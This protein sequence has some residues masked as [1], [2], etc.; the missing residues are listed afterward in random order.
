[1]R[2]LRLALIPVCRRLLCIETWFLVCF[3]LAAMSLVARA[4]GQEGE[5]DGVQAHL[6]EAAPTYLNTLDLML[7]RTT[8]PEALKLLGLDLLQQNRRIINGRLDGTQPVTMV[9]YW[10]PRITS[11][12]TVPV[13]I[14]LRGAG[15]RLSSDVRVTARAARNEPEWQANCLYKQAYALDLPSIA[16][17]FN[18]DIA[19]T[20]CLISR[21][22][23]DV[24]RV[25][26]M[27]LSVYVSPVTERGRTSRAVLETS[28][29]KDLRSLDASFRLGQGAEI[30]LPV[31]GEWAATAG[32]IGIVSAFSYGSVKQ[33]QPVCEILVR[34]DRGQER[35]WHLLSGVD[36]ART[37]YDFNPEGMNH[38]PV[39]EVESWEADYLNVHDRPFQKRNYRSILELPKDFGLLTTLTFRSVN[40]Y[41]LEVF[42][43]VMLP[44]TDN[45]EVP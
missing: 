36:T 34:D 31:S 11:A 43:V 23:T 8:R 9:C 25:P 15:G 20:V 33:D 4:Y 26:L 35:V 14:S 7:D 39:T 38:R 44:R 27:R 41:I 16:R 24:E 17:R 37:D 40:P 32:A 29:G 5:G 42:D 28:F 21:G 1:M 3:V 19:L 45:R 12:Q 18:G 13:E 22:R 2:A 30:V 10:I 6:D